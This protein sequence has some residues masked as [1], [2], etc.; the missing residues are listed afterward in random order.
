M[1]QCDYVNVS[2]VSVSVSATAK[3]AIRVT[4]GY[5]DDTG[6]IVVSASVAPEPT[7]DDFVNRLPLSLGETVVGKAILCIFCTQ[8]CASSGTLG[9]RCCAGS[10]IGATKEAGETAPVDGTPRSVWYYFS[11][12][13][14]NI[15]L[16][17]TSYVT[18]FYSKPT[19]D[20]AVAVYRLPGTTLAFAVL[21][22][23]G[24]V[25][26][27]DALPFASFR[28]RSTTQCDR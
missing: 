19:Y 27:T 23:P 17:V 7:N 9:T 18:T 11:G 20:V 25:A 21:V 8:P 3:Y 22:R 13:S 4:N 26:D 16:S 28:M 1:D 15:T 24:P 12:I 14:G 5:S 6:P 2:C 10:T